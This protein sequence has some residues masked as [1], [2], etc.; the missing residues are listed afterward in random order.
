MVE[1]LN[2]TWEG[3][4]EQPNTYLG[5]GMVEQPTLWKRRLSNDPNLVKEW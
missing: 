5:E 2:T 3:M 4:V 1:R